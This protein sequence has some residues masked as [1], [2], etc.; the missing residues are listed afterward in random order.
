M[1][2]PPQPSHSKSKAVQNGSG[3]RILT[4]NILTLSGSQRGLSRGRTVT[5]TAARS[6]TVYDE[7]CTSSQQDAGQS[8]GNK[9]VSECNTQSRDDNSQASTSKLPPLHEIQLALAEDLTGQIFGGINDYVASGAF[10]NVYRCEWRKPSGPVKVWP[11]DSA[12]VTC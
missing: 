11:V 3:Q 5:T 9:K 6:D 4:V 12:G 8:T 7:P 1:S 2:T 10:A